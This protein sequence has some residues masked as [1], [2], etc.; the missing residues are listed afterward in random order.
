[1]N[2]QI[3]SRRRLLNSFPISCVRERREIGNLYNVKA[4]IENLV[5]HFKNNNEE[6]L[7]IKQA[8][9]EKV[10]DVLTNVRIN[11][12]LSIL[13][14]QIQ[15]D[16]KCICIATIFYPCHDVLQIYE[17]HHQLHAY[18]DSQIFLLSF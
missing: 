3:A 6:Y 8:A 11:S 15:S 1:L 2:N 16:N 5:T 7:K 13:A 17:C 18:T 14:G 4:R 9:E 12:T 10:K